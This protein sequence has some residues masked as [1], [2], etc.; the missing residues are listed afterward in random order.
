MT[1]NKMHRLAVEENQRKDT[2]IKQLQEEIDVYNSTTVKILSISKYL[3]VNARMFGFEN[4]GQE[5]ND[6]LKTLRNILIEQDLK[7]NN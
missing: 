1:Q 4:A 5:L 6:I 7:D 2:L 3:L